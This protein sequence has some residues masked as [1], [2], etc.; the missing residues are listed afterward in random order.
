MFDRSTGLRNL[1]RRASVL[2]PNSILRYFE[3]SL[4]CVFVL[5]FQFLYTT[6]FGAYSAY[7]FIKTGHL[8]APFIVHAF[9]NH[10]GFPDFTELSTYKP[11]Q[12]AFAIA[13]FVT[14]LITWCI[15][16]KPLT[17]PA[18]YSNDIY[19]KLVNC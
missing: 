6:L 18:L 14:G 10:M 15:L 12:K 4:I 19:S 16:L 17:N 7:L 11:K 13:L 1:Y 9:C 2:Q 8:I 5:G 3:R